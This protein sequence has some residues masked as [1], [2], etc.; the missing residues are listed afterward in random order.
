MKNNKTKKQTNKQKTTTQTNLQPT[1]RV[2][3]QIWIGC[4]QLIQDPLFQVN[5]E[6]KDIKLREV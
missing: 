3:N 5:L 4:E 2:F 1:N 6:P